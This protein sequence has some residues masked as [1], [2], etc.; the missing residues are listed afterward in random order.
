MF[1][2]YTNAGFEPASASIKKGDTVRF[3]NNSSHALWIASAPT[4]SETIYPGTSNCGGGAFDT[5]MP[6]NP[7]DFWE[8]TFTQSGAWGYQN[9]L[10][11]S[12]VAIML[13]Q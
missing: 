4:G 2:S 5:C 12:D 1:I 8:F 7:G 10:N 6:L 9:N 3:T 13:V 11:K